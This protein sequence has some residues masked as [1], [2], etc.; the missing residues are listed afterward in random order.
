MKQSADIIGN[1]IDGG[2]EVEDVAKLLDN[3]WVVSLTSCNCGGRFAWL[4]P[5]GSGSMEMFGCLC[6]RTRDALI[7]LT[8]D[9]GSRIPS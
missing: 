9:K 2:L 6:H 4:L 1:L 7:R 8:L 5:K 3:G